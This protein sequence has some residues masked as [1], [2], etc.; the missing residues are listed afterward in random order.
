MAVDSSVIM[1]CLLV[2]AVPVY[3]IVSGSRHKERRYFVQNIAFIGIFLCV[4]LTGFTNVR[5]VRNQMELAQ[6]IEDDSRMLIAGSIYDIREKNNGYQVFIRVSGLAM[7]NSNGK[8]MVKT[9]IFAYVDD[10]KDVRIGNEIVCLA[11]ISR[12]KEASNP[13]E[14][15][16]RRYYMSRGI[17]MQADIIEVYDLGKH[18][19]LIR[20]KLYEIRT[21]AG[22]I[23]GAV[24]AEEDASVVRAMLLGDKAGLDKD[25]KKLFQ[26]NG[27]AHILAISGVLNLILGHILCG[28]N[29]VNRAFQTNYNPINA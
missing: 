24:F 2:V 19:D 6:S 20:Q 29:R 12:L 23:I 26:Q 1:A 4:V 22:G 13:G 21:A 9:C 15:D 8:K 7:D 25:T 10:I 17:Y 27:I 11:D 18:V 14:F 5:S 28:E 3:T 16:M